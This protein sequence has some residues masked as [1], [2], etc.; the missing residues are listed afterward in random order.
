MKI[1]R[2]EPF[3]FMLILAMFGS[4]LFFVFCLLIYTLRKDLSNLVEVSV[5]R[6]FW[7]STAV[8]LLSSLTLH[9]AQ[10]AFR[11]DKYLIYRV[12]MGNTLALGICFILMQLVGWQ[13]IYS[14]MKVPEAVTS[15]G[16]IYLISG[17]HLLHIVVGLFFLVKIFVEALR[18]LSYVDSFV[19]SV[20]PPN[21]LKVNLIIF[22]WHFVDVLWLVLFLFLLYEH[23]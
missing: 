22:Y 1:Q 3:R 9:I 12:L 21:K 16:F 10:W 5:P 7:A 2:Q 20:N 19:Y 13:S 18:R 15:A 14:L 23:T 8:M 6:V 4:G 11:Q 17:M